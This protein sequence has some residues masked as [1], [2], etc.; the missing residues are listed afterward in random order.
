MQTC[1]FCSHV[2][3]P[4]EKINIRC[5]VNALSMYVEAIA[6]SSQ[7]EHTDVCRGT[8]VYEVEK[9]VLV[10]LSHYDAESLLNTG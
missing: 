6:L 1:L 2:L 4:H 8:E 5:A 9:P 3:V 10:H 7:Q